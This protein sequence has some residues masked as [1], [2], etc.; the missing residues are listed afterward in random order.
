MRML[1]S[2]AIVLITAVLALGLG[3][4]TPATAATKPKRTLVEQPIKEVAIRTFVMKGQVTELQ[5]DGITELPYRGKVQFQRKDCRKCP[6]KTQKTVKTNKR[7]VYK[8]RVYA[9]RTGRWKWRVRVP[10]SDGFR[11]TVGRGIWLYYS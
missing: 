9:P 1:R 4:T 8:S 7:G 10:G 5:A 3:V 6:W 2:F 11:A